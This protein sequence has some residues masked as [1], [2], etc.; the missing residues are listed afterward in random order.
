MKFS[1]ITVCYNSVKT[2]EQTIQSVLSQ[3]YNDLEYIIVDGGSTD[4]T[5]DIIEK[6][7]KRIS[8]YI[9]EPDH[10]LYDAM[11]KGIHRASGDVVAFLNSDDWYEAGTL[12]KVRGYFEHNKVDIVSGNMY[13]WTERI[14]NKYAV[15]RKNKENVF[16]DSIYPQPALFVKRKMYLQFGGFDTS[17]KVAADT[18]WI[19]NAY[20]N[21]ANIL[22]V[23]DCFTY[24]R[25]GGISTVREYE[26]I[27]EQY[28]ATLECIRGKDLIQLEEKVNNF[29]IQELQKMKKVK[30]KKLFKIA[31]ENRKAK[32]QELFDY[33]NKYYIWG[34][35]MR[36]ALC[37]DTFEM[38]ELPIAGFIDSYP[39]QKN[40]AEYPVILPE[41]INS[42]YMI[43]ITPKNYQEEIIEQ[44]KSMG[45]SENRYFTY[46]DMFEKIAELGREINIL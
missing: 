35:G 29:Y 39:K 40:V 28:R 4:G 42:D 25:Y 24:F 27:E 8:I 33:N 2:V 6:Y 32:V 18:K 37:L 5:S 44:L 10:G 22:C 38:L 46:F 17:Y 1:I 14:C 7:K 13:M 15:D 36:G 9:S 45:I 34:V 43:C 12:E 19:M 16:F 26:G 20:V 11:N 23:D 31:L 21:G 30:E 3:N 41:E